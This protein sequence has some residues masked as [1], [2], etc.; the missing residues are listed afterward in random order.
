MKTLIQET[1]EKGLESLMGKKVTIFCCRYIY[2]GELIGIDE[3]NILLKNPAIVYETGPFDKKEW[4][5]CQ[6]LNIPEWYIAIQ[7]IESYGI[8]K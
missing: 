4:Q 8:L 7:S 1:K 5:D 2:T 6:S 3:Q